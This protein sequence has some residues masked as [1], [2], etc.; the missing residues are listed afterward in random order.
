VNEENE[1]WYQFAS[2]GQ[3]AEFEKYADRWI[4][5]HLPP[6]VNPVTQPLCI[7]SRSVD[8]VNVLE[9]PSESTDR[10][11]NSLK[12]DGTNC[13]FFSGW[14]ENEGKVWYQFAQDQKVKTDIFGAY[15]GGWISGEY[16][17]L[18]QDF[19]PPTTKLPAVTLTPTL[20]PSN[21]PAVAPS[22]T[23]T[24]TPTATSTFTPTPTNT[25]TPSATPTA[26]EAPTE[27]PT[28]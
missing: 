6:V 1:I 23:P 5:G 16:L 12:A 19:L 4:F 25:S 21:T 15:A 14:R 28:P 3:K 8:T 24:L 9:G 11:G 10:K 26:T 13:P 7:H 27:T 17:A 18:P 22:N 20:A 2:N